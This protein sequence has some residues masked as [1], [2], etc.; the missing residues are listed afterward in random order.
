MTV[1]MKPG[2]HANLQTEGAREAAI[3]TILII[4][5]TGVF[6]RQLTSHLAA[7]DNTHLLITSRNAGRA[8]AAVRLFMSGNP[9]AHISGM[10]LDRDKN[11][12]AALKEI[13]P[14]LVIDASGPFQ[15]TG[16]DVPHAALSVGAH[17]I[18]LA[19]A[20]AYLAGY[21]AALDNRAR[22]KGC[23]ALAGASSTPALSVAVVSALT[24]QWQ[25]VDTVDICITPGGR[26]DVGEAVVAAVLSYAGKPVPV[27]RGG[28]L[29]QDFGWA[30][31][32]YL[33]MPGLGS[34]RVALVETI[35][36]ELL[37]GRHDVTDRVAFYAGLENPFEQRG[38]EY[39][40]RL[41][42]SG[43][44]V[45]LT[46]LAPL[47]HKLRKFTRIGMSEVGGMVVKA[48]GIGADGM[49]IDAAWSLLAKNGDGPVVPTLAAAAVVRKLL[50]ETIEPG[51][52]LACDALTLDDIETEMMPYAITTRMAV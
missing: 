36:A 52:G 15:G 51:A 30:G 23:V 29:T 17:C 9:Q 39:L 6:G 16:Y 11:L 18:D 46:T 48:S 5:G 20:R 45:R 10:A 1:L 43:L 41:A 42:R 34:R 22:K 7:M 28:R 12:F 44:P 33:D 3:R 19:D 47:L 25:S 21:R 49:K 2:F 40:G 32:T 24:D 31:A 8:A 26:A 13:R 50:N 35:D 27:W 37:G 14:F 4:G 38:M